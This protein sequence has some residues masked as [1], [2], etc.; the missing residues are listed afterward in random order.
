MNESSKYPQVSEDFVQTIDGQVWNPMNQDISL[1]SFKI[2][3][4]IIGI[5]LNIL[6]G[7]SIIRLRRLNSKPRNIFL[8]G[9]I[10]ANLSAFVPALIEI[11][12]YFF[13]NGSSCLYYSVVVGVPDVFLLLS[14]FLSLIDRFVAIGHPLW[15]R[16]KVTVPLVIF[17]LIVTFTSIGLACKLPFV[18]G[19]VPLGCDVHFISSRT[20]G[21]FLGVLFILCLI[22]RIIV[23]NQTKKLLA[24]NMIHHPGNRTHTTRPE[25]VTGNEDIEMVPMNSEGPR[26]SPSPGKITV[27]MSQKHLLK[28]EMDATRTMVAGVTS[29]LILCCPLALFVVSINTCRFVY[30]VAECNNYSW[31][32]AYLKQLCIIHAIYHPIMYLV[33]NEEFS[34]AVFKRSSVS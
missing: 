16:D 11:F 7:T 23:Y 32:A 15:H 29:L 34:N 4:S 28:M 3:G 2:T 10:F 13:P 17:G 33:W 8:L 25:L 24:V 5:P 9:I 31:L 27:R 12:N 14:I 19:A 30:I 22:A 21:S 1:I 26:T 20:L 6:F 18:I